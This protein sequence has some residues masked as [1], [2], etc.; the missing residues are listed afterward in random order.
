MAGVPPC[1]RC[2]GSRFVLV[3]RDGREMAVRCSCLDEWRR[4]A[5]L[6]SAAIPERY[7]HCTVESFEIWNPNDPTLVKARRRTQELLDAYPR[8]ERGLLYMGRVG[9]GKTHLAVAALRALVVERG[10][11]GLYVNVTEL[12]QQLQ[13]SIDGP[14]PSREEILQPVIDSEVLVLDELGACRST[15]W[16]LD[17]LY[18]VINSRYMRQRLTLVTT[19][20]LDSPQPVRA[21]TVR[22]AE[23]PKALP[24]AVERWQ[25]TLS[26][27]ITDRL[28]SR[29]YEMCDSI[30]LRGDDYRSLGRTPGG[31]R[32]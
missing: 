27:R 14:G 12:I 21:R 15:E 18:Y 31:A 24:E 13:M 10:V 6:A 23:P 32:R 25:E 16:V 11:Q 9:T 29:L 4:D 28:R 20:F 5:A 30:E 17:Q 1:P 3:E 19:N 22:G 26:D 2:G 7:R 8:V